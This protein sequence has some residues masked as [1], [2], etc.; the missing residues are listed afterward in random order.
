M[1]VY[2]SLTRK[3]EIFKPLKEGTI[4]MYLCG[5]TVYDVGHIGHARAAVSFDI[6]RRYL[7]YRGNKVTFVSNYT[8]IDDKIIKR[9]KELA[10]TESE[11]AGK[12]IPEYERDY[13]ALKILPPDISPKAT[14]YIDEMTVL[15]EK[16]LDRGFAYVTEDGVYFEVKKFKDYGN[17]SGQKLE[18]LFE[19]ARV[20][21]DEKKKNPEDFALWKKEKKGEP[22]WDGPQGMRGRPGWHIECSAMSAKLLGE[23]FDIHAGGK[24]LIFP[25]H[26]DEIAQSE[27]A[28]GKPFARYWLHNGHVEI[29]K[30]KM[31]KSLGN[32]VTIKDV[33]AS[34]H[35]AVLRYFLLSTHYRMPINYNPELL[36]QA[37][38]SL[39]RLQDFWRAVSRMAD[40]ARPGPRS[41]SRV[42]SL[43]RKLEHDFT[44]A[45][46][47]DFEISEAL[48]AL[49]EFIRE[50]NSLG[51]SDSLLPEEY[52]AVL[53]IL[54]DF[55][56]VLAVI[57]PEAAL[58]NQDVETLI[59]ER[60][61]AR[62]NKDFKRADE[63]RNELEKQ[64]ILLEDTSGGTIWKRSL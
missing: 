6:I 12:I 24:D 7:L 39:T 48:A 45:M 26:E 18:E 54:R 9:A 10:I 36:E 21:V 62:E 31:A 19:G 59:A 42:R 50:I 25:H 53:Q 38:A 30:E 57:K 51:K 34:Y 14:E 20:A 2:N 58:L 22:S 1:I 11:L 40:N 46:D 27:A 3:R 8:D 13:G 37:K 32:F 64:G 15:V 16:L 4:L 44:A 49:F 29:N 17:L 41:D 55:D 28:N 63:I 60:N 33:L 5:P 47:D 35:P 52:A 43:L 56:Q 61:E 23:T